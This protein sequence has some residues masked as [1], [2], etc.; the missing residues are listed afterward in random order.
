MAE[1]L[2]RE[3]PPMGKGPTRAQLLRHLRSAQEVAV[4]AVAM[5]HHPFGAILVGPD[6]ET[7]LL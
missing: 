6:Q 7:V 1:D 4:R 3:S 5:G 2:D